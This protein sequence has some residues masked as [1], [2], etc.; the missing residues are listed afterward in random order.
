[1]AVPIPGYDGAE[2]FEWCARIYFPITDD[3]VATTGTSAV[4]RIRRLTLEAATATCVLRRACPPIRFSFV[5]LT[6]N[7]F[8]QDD[9]ASW[10]HFHA[11]AFASS[12]HTMP[13][14]ISRHSLYFLSLFLHFR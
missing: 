5:F 8:T 1:M 7:I 4:S 12:L 9:M 14:S 11:P 2:L 6:E 10:D 3:Y 13:T